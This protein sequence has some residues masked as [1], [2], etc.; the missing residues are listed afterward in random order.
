VP[1]TAT[2]CPCS[3]HKLAATSFATFDGTNLWVGTYDKD[4]KDA[5]FAYRYPLGAG[6]LPASAFDRKV[7]E[8]PATGR[9]A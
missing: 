6:E 7:A 9:R 5:Q 4:G 1:P 8:T 3:T 2:A